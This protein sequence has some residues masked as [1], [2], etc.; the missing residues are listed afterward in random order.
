MTDIS[1]HSSGA[2]RTACTSAYCVEGIS[3]TTSNRGVGP[4]VA[5]RA[6]LSTYGRRVVHSGSDETGSRKESDTPPGYW[7]FTCLGPGEC[8]TL[9]IVSNQDVTSTAQ[10]RA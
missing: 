3:S 6:R 7:A 10:R 8:P 4:R 5:M 1:G 2:S 9:D